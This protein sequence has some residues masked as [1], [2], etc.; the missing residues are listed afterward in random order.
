MPIQILDLDG[1]LMP[2]AGLVAEA[3]SVDARCWGPS[4]RLACRF[5]T[6]R[7]FRRWLDRQLPPAGPALTLWG[8]GD[9]HHVTLA[10]LERL[11]GPFNLMVLDQH[12]DWMRGIPF[13]H[14]GTW[15]RHALRLP[16]LRRVFHVGGERDFDNGYQPLA[17]WTELREGKVVVFPAR[18]RFERGRWSRL[19]VHPLLGAG[20]TPGQVV[21]DVLGRFRD[22][23]ACAPLY[24]SIDKDVLVGTDAVVNWESGLLERAQAVEVVATFVA[25]AEGRLAGADLLGDWS[26]VR[27]GGW[28]NRA[29]DWLDHP[30]PSPDPNEAATVNHQ[31]N[32]AFLEVLAPILS[33]PRNGSAPSFKD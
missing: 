6:F 13:L 14:C 16:N 31:A 19:T 8:S 10:F 24:I 29:C 18:R 4:L 27:L 28:I 12:P 11:P 25:A 32:A 21:R 26:A 15:L 20:G 17:P 23:L 22:D 33:A 7:R 5:A 3:I 9:F 30:S 1:A 2:Q